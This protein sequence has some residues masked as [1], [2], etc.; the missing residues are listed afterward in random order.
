MGHPI[1]DPFIVVAGG[2]VSN[3]PTLPV[4]DLD[5]LREKNAESAGELYQQVLQLINDRYANYR[6]EFAI[7]NLPPTLA[8]VIT[9]VE[10]VIMAISAADAELMALARFDDEL[11][12][13]LFEHA[14]ML[15]YGP[16][17][18]Q[19]LA[20]RVLGLIGIAVEPENVLLTD[21]EAAPGTG[22]ISTGQLT[23]AVQQY[24][25]TTGETLDADAI[26]SALSWA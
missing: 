1:A 13:E 14:E 25:L 16:A 24:N 7:K 18:A 12:G 23:Y 10:A 5:T 2:L 8:D 17:T 6:G 4:F 21:V 22:H 20:A 11:L 9:R 26:E 15:T 3:T 19:T